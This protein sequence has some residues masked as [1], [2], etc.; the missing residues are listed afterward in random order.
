MKPQSNSHYDPSVGR[1][2]SKDP[3]RFDGK[4]INLY[5][6]SMNDPVNKIDVDGRSWQYV[7]AAVIV[8][9]TAYK[10]YNARKAD[11]DAKIKPINDMK[12]DSCPSKNSDG[13]KRDEFDRIYD[14]GYYE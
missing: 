14:G 3:I 5:G 6:Y 2:L 11:I 4:D 10:L 8:G 13:S 9:Y 12:G 7:V 1:W